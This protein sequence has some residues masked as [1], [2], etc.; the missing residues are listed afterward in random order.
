MLNILNEM[1]ISYVTF[2]RPLKNSNYRMQTIYTLLMLLS[3]SI[4]SYK[5][6]E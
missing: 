2:I 6:Q 4:I 5:V 3:L 1:K